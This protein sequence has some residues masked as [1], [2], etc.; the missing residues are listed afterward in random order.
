M[1]SVIRVASSIRE[2]ACRV[3]AAAD[4]AAFWAA[5]IVSRRQSWCS[6]LW[7]ALLAGLVIGAINGL[8]IVKGSIPPFVATLSMLAVARGLMSKARFLAIDEPS[9]G[10]SPLGTER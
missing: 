10:L 9:L 1:S 4:H 7:S 6:V 3:D 8:L 2:R 5:P